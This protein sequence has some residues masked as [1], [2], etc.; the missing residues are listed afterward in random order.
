MLIKFELKENIKIIMRYMAI[1]GCVFN[2]Q[3]IGMYRMMDVAA[4]HQFVKGHSILSCPEALD[5]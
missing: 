4:L 3:M 5:G 1:R 2:Y